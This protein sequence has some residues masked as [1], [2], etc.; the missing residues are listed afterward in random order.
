MR[1]RLLLIHPPFYRL[2][3]EG[4]SLDEVPLGLGYL[5][6]VVRE[7]TDWEV[8]VLLADQAQQRSAPPG[9]RELMERGHARFLEAL[10]DPC[11]EVW[12]EVEGA[13]ARNRPDVVGI[14]VTSPSVASARRVA[15]IARSVAPDALL[16]AGGAHASLDPG[17]LLSDNTVDLCVLG[18]AEETLPI[19]LG[20]VARGG[21]LRA[22]AGLAGRGEDGVWRNLLRPAIGDLDGLPRPAESIDVVLLNRERLG[23]AA[24]SSVLTSR[25]CPYACRYCGCEPIWGRKVRRRSAG[26]VASE[27]GGL[28]SRFGVDE[29]VIRDD[30]FSASGEGLQSLCGALH[31]TGVSWSAQLHPSRV[32][33]AT[34]EMMA[35]AGCA[36]ISLGLETGSDEL[37]RVAGKAS[38][39][40]KGLEAARTVKAGGV[41]LLGYYMVGLPGE[42][43]ESLAQTERLMRDAGAHLNVLSVFTPYP[44]TQLFDDLVRDGLVPRD[45]DPGQISHTSPDRSFSRQLTDAQ[46]RD[47]VHRLSGLADRL[48]RGGRIKYFG[49]HPRRL[50]RRVL[51]GRRP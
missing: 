28:R 21:D 40:A 8:R 9:T 2:H 7:E 51:R 34:V 16:V 10:D 39:A 31:S 33:A 37:L 23:S 45:H 13:V 4:W 43:A 29:T 41:R 26:D 5:A 48:N 25:G 44:G 1:R 11:A 20:A 50:A 6:G 19:L 30:T 32:D 36:M 35:S 22:I 47:A 24:F 3:K 27:V 15:R 14:S 42:N 17:S 46:L 18:E 12:R 49:R 38:T